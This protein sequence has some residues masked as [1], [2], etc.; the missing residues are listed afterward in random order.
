MKESNFAFLP[1]LKN[2][3]SNVTSSK[4][5]SDCADLLP[6]FSI[7][8]SDSKVLSLKVS[9][10][11]WIVSSTSGKCFYNCFDSCFC[12]VISTRGFLGVNEIV[13][14]D[15]STI[16]V[17]GLEKLSIFG[18][19]GNGAKC[20]NLAVKSELVP[21]SLSKPVSLSGRGSGVNFDSGGKS[22]SK[23]EEEEGGSEGGPLRDRDPKSPEI[24]F[25]ST[26]FQ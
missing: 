9:D 8:S 22:R 16:L 24:Q 25:W 5:S 4:E 19:D 23:I 26:S 21:R 2:S 17:D 14:F 12:P 3:N 1:P 13:L 15:S 18:L 7:I 10:S 11:F 20:D 6:S